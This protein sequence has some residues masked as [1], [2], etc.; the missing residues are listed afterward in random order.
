MIFLGN[1]ILWGI[2]L[3]LV[4]RLVAAI[5]VTINDEIKKPRTIPK[6]RAPFSELR[7]P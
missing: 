3:Y 1:C 6:P 5:V 4:V 7:F 2:G